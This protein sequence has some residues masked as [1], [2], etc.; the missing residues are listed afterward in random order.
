M[1]IPDYETLML[2]VLKKVH[3]LGVIHRN[4]LTP[5][6]SD[7]FDLT[8]EERAKRYYNSGDRYWNRN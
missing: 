7:E 1:P 4:D 5:V 8:A 2:P 3:E 6:L